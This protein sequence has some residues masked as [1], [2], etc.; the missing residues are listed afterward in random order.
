MSFGLALSLAMLVTA[1][2]HAAWNLFVKGDVDRLSALTAMMAGGGLLFAPV[3]FFVPP[4]D[5]A[6]WPFIA[7]SIATHVGYYV[8]L[9]AAYRH[10]DLSLVYPIA[11]GCA[12]LLVAV[13][14]FWVAG[15]A[16]NLWQSAGVALL[17]AGIAS[18]ALERGWPLGKDG[19]PA[20]FAL[21]TACFIAGYSLTDGL[22]VRHSGSPLGY[23]AWLFL[24]EAIPLLGFCLLL[25]RQAFFAYLRARWPRALAG[26]VLS[27]G[28]YGIAI[29]AMSVATMASIV[30]L[31][32][33]SVLFGAAFGALFLGERFGWRRIL[34]AVAVVGGNLLLHLA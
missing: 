9:L 31:R 7:L 19:H 33:T 29:W 13:G 8:F 21:I 25:R 16:L 10:G 24:L 18:L 30:S 26:A 20:L 12:P 2:M 3:I 14:G 17:S 23:I 11:R 5:P 27:S 6:S 28:G 22:G 1:A 4:P 32:E 15:E 34:A